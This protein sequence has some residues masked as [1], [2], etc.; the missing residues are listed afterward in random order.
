MQL[1]QSEKLIIQLIRYL[2]LVVIVLLAIFL[3]S[4][5]SKEHIKKLKKEKETITKEFISLNKENIKSIVEKT[6]STY[7]KNEFEHTNEKLEGTLKK[8]VYNTYKLVNSIYKEYKD[9]KSKEEIVNI[10]KSALRPIRYNNDRG[11]FFITS[12][13][14]ESILNSSKPQIE[15]SNILNLK[16][17]KGKSLIKESIKIAKSKKEE[18][19]IRHW[20]SK[21]NQKG[22][23]NKE[24]EKISFVKK[25]A[26]YDWYI[27]IGEYI[28]DFKNEV[29]NDILEN[30]SVLR[31]K[32][33]E[34]VF[35]VDY[36][37]NVVLSWKN[38]LDGINIFDKNHTKNP[39]FPIVPLFRDFIKTNKNSEFIKYKLRRSDDE[40]YGKISYIKK[41]KYLNWIIGTGFNLD[42]LNR[43][44]NQRHNILEKEYKDNL[45]NLYLITCIITIMFLLLSFLVSLY[46]KRIFIFYHKKVL[47][48]E[49]IKFEQVLK[50]LKDIFNNIP[51]LINYKDTKNNIIISNKATADF[52]G[53]DIEDLK[54]V[55]LKDI[56]PDDY[57][58]YYKDDLE[59]INTKKAKV[60][61]RDVY[62]KNGKSLTV[63]VSKFPVFDEMGDV[64][65][66]IVFLSDIS[67][68]EKFRDENEKKDKIL[69]QQSKFATMGEMLAHIAHQLKQPL[70]VISVSSSS[71][72]LKK[73]MDDLSD[74]DFDYA[75]D[76]INTST[77]YLSQ[78]IDDF[79]NF[80]KP[81]ENRYSEFRIVDVIDKTLKLVD[82][83][84]KTQNIEIIKNIED[85]KINSSQNDLVQVLINILSNASD[86][87]IKYDS[88]RLIFIDVYKKEDNLFIEIKD[89]AKGIPKGLEEK[90]FETY[91]T[92]KDDEKGTG[93]GLY[94][95]RDII[96]K[97][98]MGH[99]SVENE[100]YIYENCEYTGAKFTIKL[101][102]KV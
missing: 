66:I 18:G 2:P 74:E 7:V 4:F 10:I 17:I 50:E 19:F 78:T 80:F 34:Y 54:N 48:K 76:M 15:G 102:L 70:G 8:Q 29:K 5:I 31:Y 97:L 14:G 79:R 47:E 44:I 71:L 90:I 26:P 86:E 55:N 98:L 57:Q 51:M 62:E 40:K 83:K 92:T 81:S 100:T 6:I 23:W 25:F 9:K 21:P 37:G 24:Y 52:I 13:T 89:N 101:K 33:D 65:N 99:L 45:Y 59:V 63:E 38:K 42:E 20:F 75:I 56:F 43:L 46:I 16:D 36:D 27:G 3:T 28:D 60:G 22:R 82:A 73:D 85:I 95:C 72:K 67:E 12:F 88:K 69:Y 61:F 49:K 96:S 41:F 39:N 93:L 68:K 77:K 87:L 84:F 58:R 32:D 1:K 53:C 11:Y 94:M 64:C 30:L 91:F 35:I